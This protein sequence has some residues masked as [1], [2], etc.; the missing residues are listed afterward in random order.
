MIATMVHQT[1]DFLVEILKQ[2]AEDVFYISESDYP[3]DVIH[4]Q[5]EGE[6][7][8]AQTIRKKTGIQEDTP[9]EVIDFVE[10]FHP[11]TSEPDWYGVEEKAEAARYKNL[12]EILEAHLRNIK[13]YRCGADGVK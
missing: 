9:I 10:F 2:A 1:S 11:E 8:T 4:W 5:G 7:V 13:V 6:Q 3:F 12:M